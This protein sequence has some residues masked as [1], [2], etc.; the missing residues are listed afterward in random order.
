MQQLARLQTSLSS[1]SNLY[2]HLLDKVATQFVLFIGVQT[3]C[4]VQP[5]FI[6]FMSPSAGQQEFQHHLWIQGWQ[7]SLKQH[8]FIFTAQSHTAFS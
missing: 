7:I 3:A 8:L 1:L 4:A 5:D 6:K 2:R